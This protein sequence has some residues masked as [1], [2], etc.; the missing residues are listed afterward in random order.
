M[1]ESET[2]AGVLKYLLFIGGGALVGALALAILQILG[3]IVLASVA[4]AFIILVQFI[5]ILQLRARLTEGAGAE[6][7]WHPPSAWQLDE[8][9]DE[10]KGLLG[11]IP[12]FRHSPM[13]LAG[14]AQ[15]RLMEWR[16]RSLAILGQAFGPDS[17]EYEDFYELQF[18]RA[19]GLRSER[20]FILALDDAQ[21]IFKTAIEVQLEC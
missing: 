9:C 17:V 19:A 13:P 8:I 18:E 4:V 3:F 15:T 10:L 16:R 6:S 5:Y 12:D 14:E 1:A 11:Q 20:N 21:A 7:G 2:W